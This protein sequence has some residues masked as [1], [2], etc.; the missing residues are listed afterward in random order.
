VVLGVVDPSAKPAAISAGWLRRGRYGDSVA[1]ADQLLLRVRSRRGE[2][3]RRAIMSGQQDMAIG[4][5]VE[6]MSRV[7]IGASGG[8]WAVDPTIAVAHISCRKVFR[9]I[10]RHQIRFLAR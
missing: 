5:G 9:R 1:G 4:G 3:R 6:S 2:F 10:C 8:A 7:G